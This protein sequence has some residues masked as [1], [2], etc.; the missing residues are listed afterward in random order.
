[1][2][3]V[4]ALATL[5][6]LAF[7]INA[8][9]DAKRTLRLSLQLPLRSLVGQNLVSFKEEVEAA[10][11]GELEIQ[12]FDSAQLF[13]DK[14]VPVAVGSG[15]IEMGV[16]SLGRFA[17]AVPAVELFSIPFLWDSIARL[18]AATSPES[19]VRH[20]IDD[21]ILTRTGCRILWWQPYSSMVLLTKGAALK[22]PT[23]LL[24]KRVR[25]TGKLLS[26]WVAGNRG[27]P[28]SVPGSDQY[29]AFKRGQIDIAMAGPEAIRTSK[30]AELAD[31]VTVVNAAQ[32]EFVVLINDKV[33]HELSDAER[34]IVSQ[35]ARKAESRLQA[36]YI[37]AENDALE[38][39]V[40]SNVVIYKPTPAEMAEWKRSARPAREEFL[41][42]AGDLGRDLYEAAQ[43]IE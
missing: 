28:V 17:E 42:S 14:V 16:A 1:M 40:Q 24:G 18:K 43:A 3:R 11:R 10:T 32:S 27:I 30:L 21:L 5:L 8:P 6:L 25:V 19:P 20:P 23:S 37:Q 15:Q 2:R 34:E 22:G 36:D 31:T 39:L 35:A 13:N 41:K 9:A 7:S 29:T 4:I 26:T 38:S 33:W 12:I